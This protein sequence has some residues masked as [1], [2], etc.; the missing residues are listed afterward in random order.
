MGIIPLMN[1]RNHI[2]QISCLVYNDK[3]RNNFDSTG[4]N[5]L[6]PCR[7]SGASNCNQKMVPAL[8]CLGYYRN[9]ICNPCLL[10]SE[11]DHVSS[12]NCSCQSL[13]IY[14]MFSTISNQQCQ[15]HMFLQ[16][17]EKQ[18]R[19]CVLPT[20]SPLLAINVYVNY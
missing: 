4:A 10:T 8:D 16:L 1:C 13:V 14:F 17:L 11:L 7:M 19:E 6:V 18:T 9:S 12:I 15:Q 5:L 20:S 3:W 2:L